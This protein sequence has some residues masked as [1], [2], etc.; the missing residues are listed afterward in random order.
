MSFL[1][2]LLILLSIYLLSAPCSAQTHQFQWTFADTV[3]GRLIIGLQSQRDAHSFGVV[4]ADFFV[5][6]GMQEPETIN[7][8]QHQ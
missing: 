5:S 3:R 2:L 1:C 8:K 6:L 7:F 4:P